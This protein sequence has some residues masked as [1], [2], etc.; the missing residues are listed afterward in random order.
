MCYMSSDD[1]KRVGVRQLRQ[2]LSVYLR[3]VKKGQTYEVAERG[4]T[5]ALLT[6]APEISTAVRRLVSAGRAASPAGDLLAL[7][8]PPRRRRKKPLGEALA[9]TRAERL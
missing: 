8:P 6:P 3:R 5:V 2:N 9:R 1:E 4:L 7:G